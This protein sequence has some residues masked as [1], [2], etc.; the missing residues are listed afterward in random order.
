[1]DVDPSKGLRKPE[2]TSCP[3]WVK[4]HNIPLVAFN[5]EGVSRIASVL[6][7][8]KQ[9]DACTASMCEKAWG[10]PGF[11]KV[12]VEV[13]SVGE[14]KRYIDVEIPNLNGGDAE[15]VKIQ[16]EYIWEPI[17]CSHCQVFGHKISTCVKAPSMKKG[18]Q[19]DGR[20][21][22]DGFIREE[23]KHWGPK[24]GNKAKGKEPEIATNLVRPVDVGASTSNVGQLEIKNNG[25]NDVAPSSAI[26]KNTSKDTGNVG[27][28]SSSS[29]SIN[30]SSHPRSTPTPLID[31]VVKNFR[32]PRRGVLLDPVVGPNKYGVLEQ[33][34]EEE[35]LVDHQVIM[36]KDP[37]ANTLNM[38]RRE[39]GLC[40]IIESHV[41]KDSLESV[42]AKLFGRWAWISNQTVS[43]SGT[44]IILAWNSRSLDVM[45]MEVQ[46]QFLKCKV[47]L[48]GGQ[49]V[50]FL[51]L[52]YG[53]NA[54][55]PRRELWSGLRKFK[56]LIGSNPWIVMGDFN[57]ML[58]PHDG[59]GGS[60]RRN[61]DM[62]DFFACVEDVEIFDMQYTGVH[63]SWNQKPNSEG[64]IMRKLDRAMANA[65]FT[66]K[67]HDATVHFHPAGLSDH[68]PVVL[69]FKGG[70]RKT[71]YGF[72]FDNLMAEHP[73]FLKIVK[74]EWSNYVEGTFMFKVTSHLKALKVPLRRLQN[75]FGNLG[76]RVSFLKIELDRVQLDFDNNPC[77]AELGLELGHLRIAYQNACW[78]AECA[79]K[80]RAKVKWLNEGDLNTKFFHHVIKERHHSN[81]IQSVC[82]STGEFVHG[83]DVPNI[84]VEYFRDFLG[85]R[86]GNHKA[87]G[88]DGF[89]SRFFK[90]S[91]DV[92]GRDV[93]IAIHN[94]F[95]RGN[96]PKELN[97][98]L[99]CLI[100][101]TVNASKV[102]DY[103]PI[104]CC[105]VLYKCISKVIVNR[106]KDSLD[107]LI[108]KAQSAFIPGRKISDNILMAHELVSGYQTSVGPPRCAFKI[109]IKKAYD[110]VDW[111]FLIVMMHGL[112]FHPVLIKWIRE[113]MSTTSYS[114]AI[115]GESYGFFHGGRGLRQGD[116]LSP[117]LFTIIKEGFSMLLKTCIREASAFGYHRGC[118]E[119]DITH[120]CFADDLFVFTKGD[121]H[122]VEVLKKALSLFHQRSGL[123]PSLEKSEIYFGNVPLHIREAILVCLPFK[124]GSFPVRYLG[125]PL[126]H[127]RL[128]ISYYRPLLAKVKSRIF[129][130]KTKFLLFGVHRQLIIAVLQSLQLH[131]L[132]VFLFPSGVIIESIF[133]KFFWAPRDDPRG[134]CRLSWD[135]VCRPLELGGLGIKRLATWNRALLAKHVWDIVRHHNSLWVRWIYSHTLRTN[136]FWLVRKSSNWSWVFRKLLDIR[137]HVRQYFVSQIGDGTDTN[138]WEDS[139]LPCG[140]L[141]AFMSYRFIYSCGFSPATTERNRRLFT[142][143][144]RNIEQ[145]I[146]AIVQNVEIRVAWLEKR[147]LG[148]TG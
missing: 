68:S 8:P 79:A 138:A 141:S 26:M 70:L 131:W 83:D 72:K 101:K 146:Q 93:E 120:L 41:S 51:S 58:F 60:S 114:L 90:A 92:V 23:K 135:V 24:I 78:D 25:T 67:Y 110:M 45:A 109:D 136:H 57:S 121:V 103:R 21:D 50:F 48:R 34:D 1:M 35:N 129:N 128:K 88:S 132:S 27:S 98:T 75:I 102:T 56:V 33:L 73:D 54:C 123:E 69:S 4:L 28:G 39:Q 84:F 14:L 139:W 124:L 64:G 107:S 44:R 49:D 32:M 29:H 20:K 65:E 89:T 3:L 104:A 116:P 37:V 125:V 112:G 9:M 91:W 63:F 74:A 17:Q 142:G 80:Q 47:F 133:R 95:Y 113:M 96:L 127:A 38:N 108:D 137:I 22:A 111:R 147:L 97:H 52:V 148:N 11:A 100:P 130:W 61:I 105:N 55:T 115:N 87:P 12:L 15:L 94:F 42:C 59:F 140:P 31:S 62:S 106:M 13:W 122:S 118:E 2:H 6:G 144:R 66:S 119:L 71:R 40:A 81:S 82:T 134:R 99:L 43:V 7:V 126:S 36:D 77:N 10:R 30:S 76:K 86:I 5:K 46:N 53:A 117:Y 143:D 19:V 145:I 16:V 85:L 18:K